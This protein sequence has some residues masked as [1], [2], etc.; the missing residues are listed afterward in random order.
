MSQTNECPQASQNPE[1]QRREV[2]GEQAIP[3][4]AVLAGNSRVCVDEV[5]RVIVEAQE[6][7]F[8]AG[9]R[10]ALEHRRSG[11]TARIALALDHRGVFRKRFLREGL[12]QSRKRRPRLCD[13]RAEVADIFLG[14][15]AAVGVSGTDIEVLHE[16]SAR[17]HM[18]HLLINKQVPAAL[19]GRLGAFGDDDDERPKVTC[20]AVTAEYYRAA[21]G[22]RGGFAGTDSSLEVFI[23]DDGWSQVP[24]YLRGV[25]LAHALGLQARIKLFLVSKDGVVHGGEWALPT[26]NTDEKG[27]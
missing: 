26:V 13:L 8:Q 25:A 17:T 3:P 18:E 20:A 22:I 21:A 23:E 19:V 10:R 2:I 15:A 27:G 5:G 1:R 14:L 4:V 24:T 7:A 12:P 6:Q 16:D 11:A 9:V